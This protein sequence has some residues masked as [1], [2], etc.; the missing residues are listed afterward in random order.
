VADN[1]IENE[2]KNVEELSRK[3]KQLGADMKDLQDPKKFEAL[4]KELLKG[5]SGPEESLRKLLKTLGKVEDKVEDVA[6]GLEL[7]TDLEG[8][9][10]EL[11]KEAFK[12][13]EDSNKTLEAQNR[14]RSKGISLIEEYQ[15]NNTDIGREYQRQLETH[16]KDIKELTAKIHANKTLTAQEVRKLKMAKDQV[17][18]AEKLKEEAAEIAQKTGGGFSGFIESMREKETR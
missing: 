13:M 11:A 4:F 1:N 9:A 6:E 3:L 15:K 10:L 16:S 8:E 12:S 5:F 17:T 18:A 14:A 2:I 7:W